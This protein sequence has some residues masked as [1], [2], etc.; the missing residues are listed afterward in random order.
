MTSDRP[1]RKAMPH[2]VAIEEIRRSASKQFDPA[3][4]E[5]FLAV[6]GQVRAEMSAD[7]K[8]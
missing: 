5:A 2:E 3:A 1:Y 8:V 4:V 6:V 7:Q